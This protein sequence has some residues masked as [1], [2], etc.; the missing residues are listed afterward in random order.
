MQF[1]NSSV[2]VDARERNGGVVAPGTG[3]VGSALVPQQRPII[4]SSASASSNDAGSSLFAG[5]VPFS[6]Y[7]TSV[8]TSREPTIPQDSNPRMTD[9]V[10]V[11]WRPTSILLPPLMD[12]SHF[13]SQHLPKEAAYDSIHA[14][15][16]SRYLGKDQLRTKLSS[17]AAEW[18]TPDIAVKAQPGYSPLVHLIGE[19]G[20]TVAVDR[21]QLVRFSP[22]FEGKWTANACDTVQIPVVKER[23][24]LVLARY[25]EAQI[26][27][28]SSF[29]P[30]SDTTATAVISY[31]EDL[32]L[33]SILAYR[34][35]VSELEFLALKAVDK[36]VNQHLDLACYSFSFVDSA[37]DSAVN[38]ESE[39]D[40][41]SEMNRICR[42]PWDH[43]L[44]TKI[45]RYPGHTLLPLGLIACL[46]AEQLIKVVK[47]LLPQSAFNRQ[48]PPRISV[49]IRNTYG[50]N[51][52]HFLFDQI[53]AWFEASPKDEASLV[54]CKEASKLL[55]FSALPPLFF[56]EVGSQ[57]PFVDDLLLTQAWFDFVLGTSGFRCPRFV[58]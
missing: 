34:Y 55:D 30:K 21:L 53:K 37:M 48:D 40:M 44:L 17:L 42:H 52:G 9:P 38:R 45:C 35:E 1:W 54:A 49:S 39:W 13:W 31:V 22:V 19:D 8:D 14:V 36:V 4:I 58:A 5:C 2:W 56:V 41:D 46:S 20:I 15:V 26:F 6:F 16:T 12:P 28:K 23:H 32:V 3:R 50:G 29:W 11:V 43:K 18:K 47:A 33:L 24:L 25:V 10:R 7:L 51:L 57:Q 27:D